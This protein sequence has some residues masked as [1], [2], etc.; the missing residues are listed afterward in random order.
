ML[1]SIKKSISCT[2][3]LSSSD[4]ASFQVQ[5]VCRFGTC[6]VTKTPAFMGVLEIFRLRNKLGKKSN[7]PLSLLF[8]S[9]RFLPLLIYSG[10]LSR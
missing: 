5:V 1:N 4:H 6:H 3:I 8:N 9:E 7:H 10:S 2:P